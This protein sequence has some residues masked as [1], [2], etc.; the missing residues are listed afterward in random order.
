MDPL[1][2][3]TLKKERG[4]ARGRFTRKV[5][6]FMDRHAKG[7]P[8]D[9]LEAIYSEVVSAFRHLEEKCESVITFFE[10][11]DKEEEADGA[12]KYLFDCD[13]DR[14]EI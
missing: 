11:K 6:L 4:T 5:N 7:D 1:K 10:D 13:S 3:T 8:F 12:R 9:V 14:C 2:R